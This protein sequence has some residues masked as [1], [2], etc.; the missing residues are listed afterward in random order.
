MSTEPFLYYTRTWHDKGMAF[1]GD[2]TGCGAQ[3]I[4][5]HPHQNPAQAAALLAEN[6]T[7]QDKTPYDEQPQLVA[8]PIEGMPYYVE[9][10]DGRTFHGHLGADGL[11][12]RIDTLNEDEYSVYWGDE[13]LAKMDGNPA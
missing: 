2:Q 11:L 1:H 6:N 12:P 9:T 4:S 5:E 7:Q 13:A 8:P 3:L 10:M